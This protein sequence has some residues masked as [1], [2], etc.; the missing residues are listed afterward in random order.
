MARVKEIRPTKQAI[1][2]FDLATDERLNAVA[3]YKRQS[4]SWVVR[5]LV[6]L[7]YLGLLERGEVGLVKMSEL[8]DAEELDVVVEE[9]R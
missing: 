6:N 1:M 7:A 8:V 2:M 4:R 5:Q 3:S 9:V